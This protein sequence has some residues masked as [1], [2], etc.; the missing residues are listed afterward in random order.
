MSAFVESDV[1][2]EA[3]AGKGLWSQTLYYGHVT[4]K[5]LSKVTAFRNKIDFFQAEMITI[6]IGADSWP[7][8]RCAI[9]KFI[10]SAFDLMFS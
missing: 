8:W 2:T 6:L 10:N 9:A 3:P 4:I 1:R 5:I 7:Q